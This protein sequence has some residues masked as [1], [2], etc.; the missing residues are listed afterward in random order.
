MV[1][2][3]IRRIFSDD[4]VGGLSFLEM[5]FRGWHGATWSSQSKAS[6]RMRIVVTWTI[7]SHLIA[8]RGIIPVSLRIPYTVIRRLRFGPVRNE[9]GGAVAV[10]DRRVQRVKNQNQPTE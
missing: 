8:V 1:D 6:Y 10:E 3:D 2:C 7:K 9:Q 5:S 4:E